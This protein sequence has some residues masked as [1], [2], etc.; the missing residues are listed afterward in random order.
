VA[1]GQVVICVGARSAI[2]APF[3]RLGLVVIDE[4][5][6]PSYKQDATPRYHARQVALW[7]AEVAGAAVLLGSATPAVESYQAARQGRYALIEMP[8]RVGGRPFAQVQTVDLRQTRAP[9]PHHIPGPIHPDLLDGIRDRVARR[10]QVILF[11]N[12]RG[13]APVLQCPS[14]GHIALCEHCDVSLVYH[15]ESRTLCC[16][17][18]DY[19]I[20]SPET[21]LACGEPGL[22]HVG[23]G[24]ERLEHWLATVL[25][26]VRVLR[27]DRDSTR[28][29][30]AHGQILAQ[31][32]RGEADLL[33]GTQMVA[34]GL[35]FE[36]VTLVGVVA[37]DVALSL[38][39]FR[40]AERTFQLLCQ[41][42]GRA[43]RGDRRGQVIVQTYN[44][45]HPAVRAAQAQDYLAFFEHEIVEREEAGYP[46]F[47][48]IARLV[49]S[50]EHE[51]E[52]QRRCELL[53]VR[54]A[55]AFTA[56]GAWGELLG[57]APAP[58]SKLHDKFRCHLIIKCPAPSMLQEVMSQL[59]AKLEGE[60]RSGLVIDVDPLSLM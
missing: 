38:P 59:D 12:R 56:A 26:E 37:A 1:R 53:A 10:E 3:K 48:H 25:P 54:A 16:H 57:P 45:D 55:E 6:E 47:M 14:C 36:N 40:A 31:F 22:K 18:C 49:V 8:E 23:F 17:H 4:E 5:H 42:A 9:G 11:L 43:G 30:N 34:K 29:K 39:D 21:C 32:R 50:D 33:L 52:A 51:Y 44:P 2:F 7:R 35:D 20:P 58:L 27:L 15:A 46:P 13:F 24:T 19:Q 28:R 41:V 60:L